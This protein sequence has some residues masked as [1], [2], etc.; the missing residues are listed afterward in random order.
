MVAR[1]EY[2]GM[3]YRS[4]TFIQSHLIEKQKL[5]LFK[6][7]SQ[8]QSVLVKGFAHIRRYMTL[9]HAFGERL[10]SSEG[11]GVKKLAILSLLIE[12]LKL[13]VSLDIQ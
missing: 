6:Y 4:K 8:F 10:T 3:I 1:H 12:H 9:F 5:G 2:P 13:H 11:G 7:L